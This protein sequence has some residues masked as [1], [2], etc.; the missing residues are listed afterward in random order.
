MEIERETQVPANWKAGLIPFTPV[1]A[2]YNVY[3]DSQS[4]I[5]VHVGERTQV[6]ST[7]SSLM[8]TYPSTNRVRRCSTSVNMPL[9]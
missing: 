9:S 6:H 5:K 4:Q 1:S 8:A 3:I 7:R 2:R